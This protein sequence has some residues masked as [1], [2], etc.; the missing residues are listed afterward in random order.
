MIMLAAV[1]HWGW[2]CLLNCEIICAFY[3]PTPKHIHIILK[4]NVLILGGWDRVL[5]KIALCGLRW[6]KL[7]MSKCQKMSSCQKDVKCQIVK[8]L[9]YGGGSQKK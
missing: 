4:E 2:L 3:F 9:D 7:N 8:R 5:E 6:F 1:P